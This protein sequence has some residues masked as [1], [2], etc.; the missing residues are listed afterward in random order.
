M[1]TYMAAVLAAPMQIE[2]REQR[3]TQPLAKG[4]V[5]LEVAYAGVCGTDVAITRGDYPVAL[6]L[7]LG[8]E[9]SARVIDAPS[10]SKGSALIGESVVCEI[11]NS[12]AAY[13][14]T[15]VCEACRRGLGSHCQRRSVMGIINHPG[16]F[17]R[18]VRA[19]V[20]NLH[21]LPRGASL[22]AAVLVEP[23]AAALR[24]FELSELEVGDTVVVL[25]C[26]RLGRLV[27]LAA[28]ALGAKVIAVGRSG[29][30][31]DLIGPYAWKRV[32]LPRSDEA[33]AERSIDEAESSRRKVRRGVLNARSEEELVTIVRDLTRGFGADIV[34][35]ATGS[36]ERLRLA[37]RLVRPLGTIAMKSTSGVPVP[38]LDTT[39]AT[40]DEVRFQGSRCGPFDDAIR[41]MRTHRAPDETW[42]TKTFPLEMAA[43]GILAAQ[44]EPKVVIE[45]A[46]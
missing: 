9:V 28:S 14:L 42:I 46:P 7:V 39:S 44:T 23:L 33:R 45:V 1:L 10:R 20:G 36:N 26:G 38:Q 29:S 24:T 13:G 27:A 37:Q 15:K 12:C 31:L 43:E 40:V 30:H 17:A 8:H 25:G 3:M 21:K 19:P 5:L 2:L 6:P 32:S 35:E 16:G 41:F 4:E 34:V 22:L 18:Y 11:N